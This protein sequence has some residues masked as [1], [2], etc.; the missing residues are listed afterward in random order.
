M[1]CD[2][3]GRN[4]ADNLTFC[5][6][7]GRR[8]R[9]QRGVAP[10]PPNGMPKV[11]LPVHESGKLAFAPPEGA[12][13]SARNSSPSGPPSAGR[14]ARPAAPV[15]SFAPAAEPPGEVPRPSIG[16]ESNG[17]PKEAERAPSPVRDARLAPAPAPA[18]VKASV[19]CTQCGSTNPPEY[20]FC[21]TCGTSLR[22][23]ASDERPAVAVPAPAAAPAPAPAAPV[24]PRPAE[25]RREP[26]RPEPP[27]ASDGAGEQIIGAPVVDIASSG[28]V[29]AKLVPCAR[30]H[31][32]SIA[33]TRFCKYCGASL[34]ESAIS[35]R[36]P[37]LPP[38]PTPSQPQAS[39]PTPLPGLLPPQP[40]QPQAAPIPQPQPQP[41]AQAVVPRP[42]AQP[43]PLHGAALPFRAEEPPNGPPPLPRRPDSAGR[44][45]AVKPPAPTKPVAPA[46]AEPPRPAPPPAKP[47]AR[48]PEAGLRTEVSELAGSPIPGEPVAL[49]PPPRPVPGRWKGGR[50]VVIVEDG[51]E[52][53]SF[54]LA[55]GQLDIGRTDG[56]IILE[57]DPYVSPRHA[58]LRRIDGS[59][60]VRDLDSTNHVYV[61]LRR[62]HPLKDGDLLLLG[63]EVLQFQTVSDGERGLGH[64]I[65]HGTFL[66]GSPATPRRAR[67]CQRT[68]EGVIR[69]VY[70]VFRDETVIGREVGDIVFTADPFLSR[71]HAVIRRNPVTSE[72]SL[73]DLD[74]S[75]GTYVAIRGEVGIADGDFLRIGQHLFRV[76]L[77]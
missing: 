45:Q 66:F 20:R 67:L 17:S 44:M 32:Q 43:S 42:V 10:T 33:G 14:R 55:E 18:P 63:L 62:P 9:Q 7:C 64:A 70:H 69:D 50:L 5:Q 48:E 40:V 49:A 16:L 35:G 41:V 21:V 3:C 59:W 71:R 1:L 77:G 74:S 30:C 56:D 11:D 25:P 46:P 53:R 38:E 6:D 19:T 36:R 39:Q 27:S 57:D 75:N 76:D 15:F 60:I 34:D 54:S 4:N 29:P 8:L 52:G 73:V 31:G 2:V 26:P 65:Q 22:R 28:S 24:V 37:A 61:R 47:I 58:R 68:V 12:L 13:D 23:P 72:I 51:S